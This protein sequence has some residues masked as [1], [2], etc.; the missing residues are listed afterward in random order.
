M[1]RW[2]VH[3]D[4]D[5]I[6]RMPGTVHRYRYSPRL[7]RYPG[8]WTLVAVRPRWSPPS[9][10]SE[11]P[12]L[13]SATWPNTPEIVDRRSI[14]R[15]EPAHLSLSL[16]ILLNGEERKGER[17]SQ[18]LA[19]KTSNFKSSCSVEEA[20]PLLLF[21]KQIGGE[22]P[23]AAVTRARRGELTIA[24]FR[25]RGGYI[26]RRGRSLEKEERSAKTQ[27]GDR[28]IGKRGSGLRARVSSQTQKNSCS[29]AAPGGRG[30][31][32]EGVVKP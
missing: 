27:G 26:T 29:P 2:S 17:L 9:P 16:S 21:I 18:L 3:Q 13:R 23:L 25:E 19:R 1:A 11:P 10:E 7:R 5:Y 24:G 22:Q 4:Y 30:F 14:L 28:G 32:E 31:S 20:L 12:V 15:L 6:A 8:M